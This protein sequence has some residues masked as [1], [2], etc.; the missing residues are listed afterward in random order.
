LPG[1]VRSSGAGTDPRALGLVSAESVPRGLA[2]LDA[3]DIDSVVRE[4]RELAAELLAAADLWI[5]VTSA[6][7][8]ADA[9]PWGF[10]A[11]AAQRSAAVAVVLDRTPPAAAAEIGEHLARM[12]HEHD[13]EDAPLFLVPETY[14]NGGL[15]PQEA[16]E[17]VRDW[18]RELAADADSR[19]A[20]VRRTLDGVVDSYHSRV[21]VLGQR[22]EAQE[23]ALIALRDA[24][25]EAYERAGDEVDEAV[26]DGSVLRGEV[27]ARWQE[28]VGT[29]QL[30]NVLQSRIGQWRDRIAAAVTG[31]PPPGEQLR[32]ALEHGVAVVIREAA[33][34]AAQ[35]TAQQWRGI[36][37]GAALLTR[38]L[39][40]VSADFADRAAA[41]VSEWQRGIL[42][43]IR[44]E[45]HGRRSAARI[46]SYGVN[47]AGLVVMLAVF[48]HTGGL[49]GGE[50]VVAG[51]ASALSQKLLEALLGDQAV[52]GLAATAREDLIS[53]ASALFD[54]ERERFTDRL[55][56]VAEDGTDAKSLRAAWQAVEAAR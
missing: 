7:R 52:R 30:L 43:L 21:P 42:D 2:L 40:A 23:Q 50:L 56:Q 34:A 53:R 38:D 26:R 16:V 12:L 15:L 31:R 39:E 32:V 24:V 37:G 45:G 11:E 28:L 51:G 18:L 44:A 20:V 9:V 33:A 48:A 54:A 41:S 55:V 49:T 36:P 22:L 4:N 1:L 10:L 27:L 47:G 35:R 3:P 13:L 14:T 6:A 25:R 46:V 5:F 19:Q 29:G 17:P 8:Y